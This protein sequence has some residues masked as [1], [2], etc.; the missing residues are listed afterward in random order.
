LQIYLVR[1]LYSLLLWILLPA[2]LVRLLWRGV[3]NPQYRRR[4]RER[5][6]HVNPDRHGYDIWLHA[7]SLGETNAATPL[8]HELLQRHPS[9]R[10]LI[11]TMTPTGSARVVS[12][13]GDSVD[14]SYAP[15]DYSFAV[16]R[17]LNRVRPSV[18]VLIETE[19]WPNTIHLCSLRNVPVIM[20]NVRL[21]EKSRRNYQRIAWL[22]QPTLRLIRKFGVQSKEHKQRLIALGVQ[23]SA[24]HRTGSMKFEIKLTAGVH[25]VAEA[26]RQD[27]GR[28]RL[29]IVAGSTHDGEE[30]ILVR[31]FQQ[32]KAVHTELLLVI[33]PR[34]PERFD[35]VFSLVSRSG[36]AVSR[37]T[38]Q[39]GTLSN[40]VDILI[41]DTLG[42]LPVL[43]SAADIAFVGGSLIPGLGGHNIL[44]P[45]AVGV[46]VVF[47]SVMPNFEEISHIATD[48]NAGIQVRDP[49][50]LEAQLSMLLNNPNL[51]ASM[52]ERG[53]GMISENS[54]ATERSLQI[55]LPLINHRI[56]S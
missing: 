25:E 16:Q 34:H 24:V 23:P 43:Y 10:I 41:A 17:F 45:C 51:R 18:L 9:L 32:L 12:T 31:I 33:A 36:L 48:T 38:E 53:I 13:F 20:L 8:I 1:R 7:V 44:E 27:W 3:R 22:S 4:L 40:A 42:E 21:S 47:G 37:R 29:V 2:I 39:Q 56:R 15:Y 46:P 28:D 14:H 26:V 50:D 5:F 35:S 19:I 55:L 49:R 30:E 52:G 6:G 54:G 11:T